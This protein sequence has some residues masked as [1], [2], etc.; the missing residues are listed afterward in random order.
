MMQC[1]CCKMVFYDISPD[2]QHDVIKRCPWCG[3]YRN[4]NLDQPHTL[5]ELAAQKAKQQKWEDNKV[6]RQW[7]KQ[8]YYIEDMSMKE[9]A[10]LLNCDKHKLMRRMKKLK[11]KSKPKY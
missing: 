10:K 3:A 1:Y 11:I 9:I 2:F 6:E 5:K 8:K 7:I 4:K